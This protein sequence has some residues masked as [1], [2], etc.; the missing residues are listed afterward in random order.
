MIEASAILDQRPAPV[1]VIACGAL[2]R[3][4]AAVTSANR[5]A[6]VDVRAVPAIFHN[7]PEKIAPAVALLIDRYRDRYAHIFVAYAECGTGGALDAVLAARGVER[8]AG[9]HCYA[10]FS[11]ADRFAAPAETDMRSFFLTDF[12]ARHFHRLVIQSLGLDRHPELRDTYFG[13]YERVVY[14]AQTADAELLARA[15]AAAM[16]LGLGFEHRP[17]GYGEL[18]PALAAA[19]A[20]RQI[21]KSDA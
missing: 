5:F 7:R 13:Q 1:L 2:V 8:L 14:L 4:I 11:G 21:G 3:D 19:A 17:V 6:T 10:V 18:V 16:R 20:W 15:E 12:L 9:A